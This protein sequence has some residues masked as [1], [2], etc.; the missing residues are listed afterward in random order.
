MKLN[1]K[2][3][4]LALSLALAGLAVGTVANDAAAQAARAGFR[5]ETHKSSNIKFEVPNAWVTTTNGDVLLTKP[6]AGGLAIEFVGIGFGAKEA[7]ATEA[8]I[9]GSIRKTMPDFH[10]TEAPKPVAQNGLSGTLTKGEGTKNG[11]RVEVIGVVLGD[12][13]GHGIFSLAFAGPGQIAANRT[14][15]IEV[16][17]SIRPN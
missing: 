13:K 6:A 15:V 8:L 9:N 2:S 17:N 1:R 7:S 14:Q 12:G 11:V 5:W 3:I 4:F 10:N 16:F